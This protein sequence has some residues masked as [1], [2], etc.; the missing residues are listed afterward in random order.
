M[1]L[2]LGTFEETV[3]GLHPVLM[4]DVGLAAIIT[5]V[6]WG[7][8]KDTGY[9]TTVKWDQAM[10]AIS[11]VWEL[12]ESLRKEVKKHDFGSEDGDTILFAMGDSISLQAMGASA[13]KVNLKVYKN[14]P[15]FIMLDNT[16]PSEIRGNTPQA[17]GH[18]YTTMARAL[19]KPVLDYK[20]LV[21]V[22]NEELKETTGV[23]TIRTFYCGNILGSLNYSEYK[24]YK[25]Q[26]LA[27]VEEYCKASNKST[28]E[29][30]TLKCNVETLIEDEV[31]SKA[32][33]F[34]FLHSGKTLKH[35]CAITG[36][37][38]IDEQQCAESGRVLVVGQKSI[39]LLEYL[40]GR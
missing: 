29:K 16:K 3:I 6:P 31:D 4:E 11:K 23:T 27:G 40:V 26:C 10:T 32:E 15:G 20:T 37:L 35:N 2:V 28:T 34:Q 9:N 17:S 38:E 12:N 33:P 22:S 1:T 36:C 39:P 18:L 5:D 19:N 7:K 8:E 21:E 14:M 30:N 13:E 24:S 25:K